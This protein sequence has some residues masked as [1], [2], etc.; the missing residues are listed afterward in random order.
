M[1]QLFSGFYYPKLYRPVESK[2]K[3]EALTK[4]QEDLPEEGDERLKYMGQ[5]ILKSQNLWE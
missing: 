1:S 2:G 3:A 4:R 5:L